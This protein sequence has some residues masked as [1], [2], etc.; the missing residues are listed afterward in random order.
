M[1]PVT[2]CP[3]SGAIIAAQ[4]VRATETVFRMRLSVPD[5]LSLM[6]ETQGGESFGE[7]PRIATLKFRDWLNFAAAQASRGKLPRRGRLSPEHFFEKPHCPL[8]ARPSQP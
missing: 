6:T 3:N 8:V 2:A 7:L 1:V 5:S 4:N